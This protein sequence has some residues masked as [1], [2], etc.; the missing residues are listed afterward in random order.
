MKR[1]S[2]WAVIVGILLLFFLGTMENLVEIVAITVRC[3]GGW[4]LE[5]SLLQELARLN[6]IRVGSHDR[7]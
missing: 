1:Q 3:V 7:C 5:K 2:C 4:F 6:Q